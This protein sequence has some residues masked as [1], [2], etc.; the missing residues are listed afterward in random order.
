MQ[1]AAGYSEVDDTDVA[2]MRGIVML[3]HCHKVALAQ[4]TML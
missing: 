3:W 2:A 1:R 4:L